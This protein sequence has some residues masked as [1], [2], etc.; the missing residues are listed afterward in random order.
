MFY[1][2]S[3][4]IPV[5]IPAFNEEER[6]AATLASLPEE[7]VDPIVAV[8]GTTDRT[9]EIVENF[10]VPVLETDE[11]GKLPAIQMTLKSLGERALSPLIILD[12][13]TRPLM[14]VL[15]QTLMNDYLTD[16]S[17]GGPVVVGGPTWLSGGGK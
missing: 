5:I 8:N 6:I 17:H 12:A 3:K 15:W 9:S 13:D 1:S 10:G 7:F 16:A 11:Q 14:P 4:K 2:G